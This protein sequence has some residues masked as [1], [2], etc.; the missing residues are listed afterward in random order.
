MSEFHYQNGEM[1]AE[2]V[3]LSRLAESVGTPAYIY[4]RAAIETAY[5]EYAEPLADIP[6]KICFAVKANSNLGV[7]NV[8][9]QQGA[10][11]DIVSVGELERVLAA[12]GDPGKVVFS[13]VGK[14]EHEI[15]RALEV[16]V[17]CF[18]LGIHS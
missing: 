12:G 13:G 1:Y 18:N 8:L 6:H 15:R 16:G 4:S 11:F 10:G 7:L 5:Q 9:A 2:Q 17:W 3:S 14:Q